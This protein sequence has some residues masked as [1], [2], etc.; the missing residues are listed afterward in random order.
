M[1]QKNGFSLFD[2]P[3]KYLDKIT[4]LLAKVGIELPP[5][6]S[7]LILLIFVAGTLIVLRK[8]FWPPKKDKPLSILSAMALGCIL[9]AIL[10]SWLHLLIK[11]LPD[12]ILGKVKTGD[13]NNVLVNV[14]DFRG[15]IISVGSG[16]VD[17]ATGEFILRYK[18]SFGDR[19]RALVVSKRNCASK[20]YSIGRV[21]L[22]AE[23]EFI[24]NFTCKA[25]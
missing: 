4:D 17:T 15:E 9:I 8:R 25:L 21:K 10:Y 6:G 2:T 20:K 7:Q 11:P 1:S 18:V 13:L 23:S 16:A 3:E 19:P 5:F 24:L 14:I 12:H 22:F